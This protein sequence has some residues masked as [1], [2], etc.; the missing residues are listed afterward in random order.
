MHWELNDQTG[1]MEQVLTKRDLMERRIVQWMNEQ[2]L[3][4]WN[5]YFSTPL[6]VL[7]IWWEGS[8]WEYVWVEVEDLPGDLPE[9]KGKYRTEEDNDATGV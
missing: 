1:M 6:G 9:W 5:K 7:H 3:F 2:D 8:R 4:G